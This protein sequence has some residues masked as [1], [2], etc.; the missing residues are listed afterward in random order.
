M[1]IVEAASKEEVVVI[2]TMLEKKFKPIY[3]DVWRVGV[4]L[5]LRISDLLSIR[6]DQLNL[7]KRTLRIKEGKTGKMALLRL[8]ENAMKIIIKRRALYP[9]HEWLFE[10]ESNRQKGK[11]LTR[12][13]VAKVFHQT[14]KMLHLNIGTHSMRKSRGM[15]LYQA[16]VPLE[17]IC[18]TLNHST[19]ACTLR[20]L[21]ITREHV[22]QTYDDYVL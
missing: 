19:P 10:G 7:E 12:S 11:P 6:Y 15:A 22:L 2:G 4:N 14:G 13:P 5:S 17:I 1:N 9:H 21:G 8:N 20:Y 3:A 18:Q 16:G